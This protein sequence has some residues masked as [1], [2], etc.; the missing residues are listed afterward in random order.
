MTTK[1]K[2]NITL[3]LSALLT[4]GIL[5]ACGPSDDSTATDGT[6]STVTETVPGAEGGLDNGMVDT[7]PAQTEVSPSAD[8]PAENDTTTAAG[9]DS[10]GNV[11]GGGTATTPAPSTADTAQGAVTIVLNASDNGIQVA[12]ISGTDTP[13]QIAASEEQNPTLNLTVGQRYTLSLQNAGELALLDASGNVLLASNGSEGT[14][15]DDGGVD[16]QADGSSLSFTL[17]Q[18]LADQIDRYATGTDLAQGG[19]IAVSEG[20]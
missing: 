13:D 19:Q 2:R 18:D 20:G 8:L 12:D 11:A 1:L 17:T 14:L 15:T 6:G 5:I 16:F 3:A 4:G 10:S 7:A 9:N